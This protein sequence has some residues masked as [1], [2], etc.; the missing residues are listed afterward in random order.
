[1]TDAIILNNSGNDTYAMVA[2]EWLTAPVAAVKMRILL[3]TAA[4]ID[5]L[6]RIRNEKSSG[7]SSNR[8]ISIGN[9]VDARNKSNLIIDIPLDPPLVL[10]G[11]TY[12]QTDIEASSEIDLLF[13][14]KDQAEL[15]DLL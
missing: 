12:F 14:F 1:M 5:N 6:I 10:D 13:Y 9:Y 3:S 11:Q 15:G 8:D 2:R 7:K 4:Q